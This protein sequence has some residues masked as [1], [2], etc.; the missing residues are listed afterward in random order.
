MS[1]NLCYEHELTDI[2]EVA[3]VGMTQRNLT[4]DFSLMAIKD[5]TL[6][7]NKPINSTIKPT[8]PKNFLFEFTNETN[9][10]IVKVISSDLG[11]C[12]MSIQPRNCPIYQ[13]LDNINFQGF[14]QTI[15]SKGAITVSKTDLPTFYVVFVMDAKAKSCGGSSVASDLKNINITIEETISIKTVIIAMLFPILLF[16][17]FYFIAT[18]SFYL[19]M[20]CFEGFKHGF[21]I[22]SR[23]TVSKQYLLKLSNSE[24]SEDPTTSIMDTSTRKLEKYKKRAKQDVSVLDMTCKEKKKLVAKYRLYVWNLVIISIFYSLPV[25]Q[26]VLTNLRIIKQTGS[27][28]MCYYNY[29]CLHGLGSVISFNAIYSN[30]GYILLGLLYLMLTKLRQIRHKKCFDNLDFSDN[31]IPQFFSTFYCLGISLVM[32]GI[33]S[34]CYHSC[35]NISNFQFDTAYMFIISGII[36]INLFEKRHADINAHSNKTYFGFALI[37]TV[38]MLD[39]ILKDT[40]IIMWIIFI[41]LHI[42]SYWYLSM[43]WYSR[44]TIKLSDVTI[45]TAYKYRQL[46]IIERK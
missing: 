7:I 18:V 37:I 6:Q 29:L 19:H 5:L 30:L 39:V 42:L 13:G 32:M 46:F 43:Q 17:A 12:I 31:G 9:Q 4:I 8:H 25:M 26:N 23:Q 24:N 3:I 38:S 22:K 33:M 10:V 2:A 15:I 45:N 11:C 27:M 28:D 20:N 21:R 14:K 1:Q 16:G 40:G 41:I 44:G 36:I 35:P 34:S